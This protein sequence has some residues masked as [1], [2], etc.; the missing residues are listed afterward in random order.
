MRLFLFILLVLFLFG[1]NNKP[2]KS[3]VI[4]TDSTTKTFLLAE[5]VTGVVRAL[6]PSPTSFHLRE[7][8][9]WYD[10]SGENWLVLYE[11]GSYIPKSKT[12][13]AAKLAAILYQKTD[14][15]FVKQW[16]MNDFITDCELDITCSF[17]NEHLLIS[18]IDNNNIA[19]V[20]MVYALSCKGDVSPNTKKLILYTNGTKFAIRGEEL[21]VMAKDT[22]GGTATA[23]AS[24]QQL[25][26]AIQDSA[27]KH[28]QKFG[29][30]KYE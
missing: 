6:L 23:D 21:M 10:A 27:M 18:D 22:V 24:F 1:C 3:P 8:K 25:P 30:T 2:S 13:A 5:D 16:A 12:G 14:S 17:Y 20:M 9:K 7:A 4:T 29:L 15:G 28:F 19:E 26:M 11:T